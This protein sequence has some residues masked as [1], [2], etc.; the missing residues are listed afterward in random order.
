MIVHA[1]T[2]YLTVVHCTD[3]HM[4]VYGPVGASSTTY[5][6]IMWTKP[7]GPYTAILPK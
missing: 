1:F 6:E 4:S 2:S 5:Q 3:G 7:R